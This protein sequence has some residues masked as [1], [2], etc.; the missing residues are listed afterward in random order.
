M[1]TL[2]SPSAGIKPSRDS[3]PLDRSAAR[4]GPR[5][6]AIHPDPAV[7]LSDWVASVA[8]AFTALGHARASLVADTLA[9]L[10]ERIKAVE[11][12]AAPPL[13]PADAIERLQL[14]DYLAALDLAADF[15]RDSGLAPAVPAGLDGVEFQLPH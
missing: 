13:D 7:P 10:A 2:A 15:H 4:L 11:S 5:I 8:G 9:A 14:D 1:S 6:L 3:L 12:P